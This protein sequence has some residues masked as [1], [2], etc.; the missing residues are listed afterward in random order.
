ME[1]L[2][3]VAS[4]YDA[5]PGSAY[6]EGHPYPGDLALSFYPSTTYQGVVPT[7][8]PIL[9]EPGE[10]ITLTFVDT[11]TLPT[12]GDGI[13]TPTLL[14][15]GWFTDEVQSLPFYQHLAGNEN[16]IKVDHT[17]P[18][19]EMLPLPY[20]ATSTEINVSWQAS[21][22]LS[23]VDYYTIQQRLDRKDPGQI[24]SPRHR[25]SQVHS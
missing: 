22:S 25:Q 5:Y 3:S 16:N 14:L 20:Y 11:A 4:L 8:F 10:V 19:V 9:L 7:N 24:G 6:S 23:G 12:K 15:Q 18:L 17:P 13:Y 1:L 21:D 2:L